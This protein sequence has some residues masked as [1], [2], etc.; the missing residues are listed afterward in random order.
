MT[1]KAVWSVQPKIRWQGGLQPC[2]PKQNPYGR[3]LGT[4]SIAETPHHVEAIE[5][6]DGEDG[7]EPTLDPSDVNWRSLLEADNGRFMTTE[8]GG[9]QYVL[10]ITPYCE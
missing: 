9:R 3:L 10:L 4:V 7:L 1:G 5:V 6:R 2:G 8:I